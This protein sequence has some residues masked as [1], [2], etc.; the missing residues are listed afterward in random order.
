MKRQ[1]LFRI[2]QLFIFV[3]PIAFQSC[4]STARIQDFPKNVSSINFEKIA[5]SPKTTKDGLR[6]AKTGFEY[7]FT[8]SVA[9]E[10][11]LRNAISSGL[12]LQGF[13]VEFTDY[14]QGTIVAERGMRA[15]E[16]NS[17]AG[18][19]YR[20]KAEGFEVYIN[21][22]ITQDFTGGWNED[23]AKKIGI[24]ICEILKGCVQS[25]S[26]DTSVPKN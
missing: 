12:D 19:Y 25:F 5:T 1:N 8:T 18:V 20:K 26:V 21:C 6:N 14:S 22:K 15:N 4:I 23:R 24:R 10:I 17:V 13:T 11:Y 2:I 16:W 7:Y 9:D 3:L